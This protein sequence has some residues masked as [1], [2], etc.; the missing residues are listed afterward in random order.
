M[1]HILVALR[2]E[3]RPL[4]RHLGLEA[5]PGGI[6]GRP[7]F[8]GRELLL[9]VTGLGKA[10]ADRMVEELSRR[11]EFDSTVGWLNVGIAGHRDLPLGTCVL[12]NEI[13]ESA[14]E[15]L[16]EVRIPF[17]SSLPQ[18]PVWTVDRPETEFSGNAAYD[19]EAS[20]FYSAACRITQ[21]GLVQVLKV[22]SDNHGDDPTHLTSTRVEELISAACPRVSELLQQMAGVVENRDLTSE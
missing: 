1:I 5:L 18:V 12:A 17:R 20:G 2:S 3:A 14:S 6:A 8:T 19:M 21:P 7:A 9:V 4:V 11:S 16:W 22:V 10:G 13:R 15:H